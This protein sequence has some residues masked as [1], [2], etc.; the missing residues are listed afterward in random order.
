MIKNY[1]LKVTKVLFVSKES[2]GL[3][4]SDMGELREEY[5]SLLACTNMLREVLKFKNV[6]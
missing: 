6:E 2:P 3:S 1:P 5:H 4:R